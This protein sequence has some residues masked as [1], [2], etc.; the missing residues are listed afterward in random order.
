MSIIVSAF[1]FQ[2]GASSRGS[3]GG[4]PKRYSKRSNPPRPNG[5]ESWIKGQLFRWIC[6]MLAVAGQ[7]LF[8][9]AV[10]LHRW[11]ILSRRRSWRLVQWSSAC[12]QAAIRILRRTRW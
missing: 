1:H 6:W 10:R 5:P 11:G 2:S 12:N 9:L 4:V 8:W 7:I 3:L